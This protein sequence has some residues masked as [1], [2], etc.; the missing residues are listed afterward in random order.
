MSFKQKTDASGGD[1]RVLVA[2]VTLA[3]AGCATAARATLEQRFQEIGIPEETALCMVDDLSQEL[4]SDDLSELARYTSRISRALTTTAAIEELVKIDN[5][6]AV[7]A[8]GRAG[9]RCATGFG[10]T[11]RGR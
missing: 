8:I 2:V 9:F 1:W 11:R 4:N 3:L 6:A 7:A 10:R 5:P